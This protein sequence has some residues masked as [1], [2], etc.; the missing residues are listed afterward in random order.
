MKQGTPVKIVLPDIGL[1]INSSIS[2]INQ[3]IG[4]SSR[5]VTTEAKI[6]F[7]KQVHINQVAQVH[8][9][10][11]ENNQAI[12]IPLT[13]LQSDEKGKYVYVLVEEKGSKIARKKQVQVGDI[14]GEQIEVRSGLQEGDQLISQGFQSLYEGQSVTTGG[15]K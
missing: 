11:Y 10:D 13:T 9:K 15:A 2:L 6:P 14:Y 3:T 4:L 12:V 5:S 7:N 1:E 8:I